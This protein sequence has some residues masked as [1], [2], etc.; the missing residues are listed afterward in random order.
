M[1][2]AGVSDTRSQRPDFSRGAILIPERATLQGEST[3]FPF[4]YLLEAARNARETAS[5]RP[6]GSNYHRVSSVLFC[7]F[8]MEAY[9]NHLGGSAIRY[10]GIVEPK[11][12]WRQKLDLVAQH[13]E[14]TID[15]G[16][17]PFGTIIQL[18][19]F[20]DKLVH[21]KTETWDFEYKYDP[22]KRD[23]SQDPDW[24]SQ[25]WNDAAVDRVLEDT[26]KAIKFLH[27]NADL[28]PLDLNCM[29]TSFAT[30]DKDALSQLKGITR[31]SAKDVKD[32]SQ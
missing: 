17:R 30:I 29:G 31:A 18:F 11:L 32:A 27:D 28:D 15:A 26:E 13:F 4:V 19:K 24:L 3:F 5:E 21:G 25:Y 8:A 9:L 1:P 2:F 23:A 10:W 14:A 7:A 6:T 12:G 20:R 22:A 16:R